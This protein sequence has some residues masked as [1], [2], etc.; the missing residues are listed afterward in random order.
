MVRAIYISEED[1]TIYIIARRTDRSI[2]SFLLIRLS[3]HTPVRQLTDTALETPTFTFTHACM[4]ASPHITMIC[5]NRLEPE[6]S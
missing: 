3:L 1:D 6:Q 4:H 2:Y 5:M